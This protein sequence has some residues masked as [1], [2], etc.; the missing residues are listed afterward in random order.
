MM[1]EVEE[2]EMVVRE[3]GEVAGEVANEAGEVEVVVLEFGSFR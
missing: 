1:E 3:T 2:V